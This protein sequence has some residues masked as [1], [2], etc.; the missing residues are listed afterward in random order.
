M[1]LRYN[2]VSHFPCGI[3]STSVWRSWWLSVWLF[4]MSVSCPY[5]HTQ[6]WNIAVFHVSHAG[7]LLLTYPKLLTRARRKWRGLCCTPIS[8]LTPSWAEPLLWFALKGKYFTVTGMTPLSAL[9]LSHP[10]FPHLDCPRVEP[11]IQG[12]W[13]VRKFR[14]SLLSC[15]I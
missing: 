4:G 14:V 6:V 9:S 15:F 12:S 5:G 8:K 3:K 2:L 11:I 7:L 1:H 10:L 13:K